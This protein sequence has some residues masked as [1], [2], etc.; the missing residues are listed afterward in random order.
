V[1]HACSINIHIV[2]IRLITL[3]RRINVMGVVTEFNLTTLNRIV[4]LR[5]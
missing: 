2:N 1:S 4:E 3:K 5:L